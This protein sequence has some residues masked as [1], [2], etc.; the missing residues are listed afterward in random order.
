MVERSWVDD[1]WEA[2]ARPLGAVLPNQADNYYHKISG[3][4]A[5]VLMG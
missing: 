1:G 2:A 4:M 3:G 5:W